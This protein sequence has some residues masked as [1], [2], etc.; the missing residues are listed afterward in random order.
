[1]SE[2]LALRG[3]AALSPFRIAKL[4]AALD[5][6]RPGHA[7]T[8][9]TAHYRHFVEV[10]RPLHAGEQATLDRLL[11][12]GPSGADSPEGDAM[13]LVIPRF[14]TIS[15]WSSKATD[16][17]G[18]CGLDAITR[19]ERGVAF[20]VV[21]T[22]HGALVDADRAA[23]LPLIHD[24]MTESVQ[25]EVTVA[26]KLFAHVA[27]RP[28]AT[29][30]LC[31]EGR[32]ALAAANEALGLALSA[33]EIDYLANAFLG[34]GRDPTDVELMMFAQANSEHCR[35]KIFNA[36]WHL[37]G[38][39]EAQSLFGMIRATHAANPAGTLVAYVDNASVIEGAAVDRFYPDAD[40]RYSAHREPTHIL[41]KV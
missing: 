24:R 4:I 8:S 19:I 5:A 18:N 9:I 40:G 10:Q 16:I 11:T 37:D 7:I 27:P 15:P 26:H 34:L 29:I 6:A 36:S 22:G 35:H 12:Y 28:L 31:G 13:L 39:S 14:G 1:M 20:D 21:T 25:D 3:R 23:L 38:K 32:F 33:D 17:A 30:P 41:I 2:V